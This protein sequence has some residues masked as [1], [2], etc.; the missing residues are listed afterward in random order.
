[1]TNMARKKEKQE[2]LRREQARAEAERGRKDGMSLWLRIEESDASDDV[3]AILH[4][5]ANGE[6]E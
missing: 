3:K 5:L 4:R 2:E 6:R 1:M